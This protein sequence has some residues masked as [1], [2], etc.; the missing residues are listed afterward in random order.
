MDASCQVVCLTLPSSAAG[1]PLNHNDSAPH[2]H[3]HMHTPRN[4][5]TCTH[6][7]PRGEKE[8]KHRDTP[9]GPENALKGSCKVARHG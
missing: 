1:G 9:V 4:T 8:R 6:I 2:Q 5:H 7:A 3:S